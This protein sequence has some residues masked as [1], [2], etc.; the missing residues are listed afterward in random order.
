MCSNIS[1]AIAV[2]LQVIV[3]QASC[4]QIARRING[5]VSRWRQEGMG[6]G[7]GEEA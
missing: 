6:G 1:I 4:T 3:A 2:E 7:R 5:V